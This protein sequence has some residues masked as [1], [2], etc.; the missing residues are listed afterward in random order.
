[1]SLLASE[2]IFVALDRHVHPLAQELRLPDADPRLRACEVRDTILDRTCDEDIREC[3]LRR[4]VTLARTR[5]EPWGTR[6]GLGADPLAA[7]DGRPP[8]VQ[9]V[10]P[11]GRDPQ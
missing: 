4:V 3:A 5:R 11:R 7:G 2:N 6:R 1:M 8:R 9:D 10:R